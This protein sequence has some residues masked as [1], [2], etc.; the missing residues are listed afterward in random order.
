MTA[1]KVNT[2][3][4]LT[5]IFLVVVIAVGGA[6]IW[7]KYH[8]RQPIE[9]TARHVPEIPGEIYIGG[10]VNNP[11]IYPVQ[12]EDSLGDLIQAAGGTT[13]D[14][15]LQQISL[16]IHRSG[17]GDSP[18]KININRAD[19]WLLVALPGIKEARAKAIVEYHR[20]NGE[21]RSTR[22]LTE[23]DGIGPGTYERIKD[24]ITVAD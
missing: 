9:I 17:E 18:Q 14:V 24:L 3:W 10:A 11:G 2:Y 20:Q 16:C 21:F 15:D 7:S 22:E 5:I 12:G 23:V 1:S 6:S 8:G 19:E 13:G 4:A